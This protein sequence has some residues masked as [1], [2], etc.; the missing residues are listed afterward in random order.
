MT[1]RREEWGPALED[2]KV[3]AAVRDVPLL[4]EWNQKRLA[5]EEAAPEEE[6]RWREDPAYAAFRERKE[7]YV[8]SVRGQ[9]DTIQ[10]GQ[11][12]LGMLYKLG[13]VYVRGLKA[14]G[15]DQARSDLEFHLDQD[16]ELVEVVIRGFRHL[17]DRP[18]LPDL[19]GIVQLYGNSKMSVFA[20]PFLAGL[21]EDEIVGEHPLQ[22][23]NDEGLGRALG[24]YL[25]SRLPTKRRP[26]PR[27]FALE[28]DCRPSWYRQALRDHPQAVADAFV[29][30]HR[31]R[32]RAK[33][34][35][36]QHL[37][38][39]TMDRRIRR[40]GTLGG[41]PDVH[42]VPESVCRPDPIG[43]PPPS[44]VGR[45]APYVF[46]RAARTDPESIRPQRNG[47]RP[48]RSVAGCWRADRPR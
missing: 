41:A 38:D 6:A 26:I 7:A 4:R 31:V 32:V 33:E 35:P 21:T 15:P 12:P 34:P 43:D 5:R 28:E 29:A 25:L 39:L 48:A 30:V 37:H 20:F 13:Q 47:H 23:L 2:D 24:F 44:P 14:G 10:A 1:Q 42:T 17:V 9:M 36:D 11:G 16:T 19:N 18:D 27:I 3:A 46:H 8:A 45:V 40:G 22:R